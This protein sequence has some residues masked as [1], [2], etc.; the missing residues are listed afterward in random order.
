M[1]SNNLNQ[2]SLKFCPQCGKAIQTGV[3]YCPECGASVIIGNINPVSVNSNNSG[4]A[5]WVVVGLISSIISIFIFPPAFGIF[6]IVC[7]SMAIKKGNSV[8]GAMI[9]LISLILMTIGIIWGYY[10]GIKAVTPYRYF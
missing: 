6:G 2:S 4:S 9:I 10:S 1:D 3:K 5:V 7:G 8:G